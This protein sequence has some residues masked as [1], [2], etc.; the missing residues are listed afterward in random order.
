MRD[1][2]LQYAIALT[3]IDDLTIRVFGI[4]SYQAVDARPPRLVPLREFG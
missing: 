3:D 4:L 1:Q 2:P